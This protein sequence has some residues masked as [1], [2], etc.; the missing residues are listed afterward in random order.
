MKMLHGWMTAAGAALALAGAPAHADTIWNFSYTGSGV[1]ASGSFET[2]G[3]GSTPSLVEWMTGTYS[4]GVTVAAPVSLVPTTHPGENI[5]P[6]PAGLYFYDNLFGGSPLLSG[7]GLLFLAGSQEVN[8][9][10]DPALGITNLTNYGGAFVTT[11][12]AFTATPAAAIPEPGSLGLML[13]GLAAFGAASRRRVRQ[14]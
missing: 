8:L 4:D 2:V 11:P 12:V 3:D 13:A 7:D 14:S 1:S 5:S 6:D 9:Y 10:A